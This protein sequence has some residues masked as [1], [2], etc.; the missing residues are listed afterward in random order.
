[1]TFTYRVLA[2]A[3][4]LACAT[5]VYAEAT[6]VDYVTYS[7]KD[8]VPP[9]KVTGD[10]LTYIAGVGN[11]LKQDATSFVARLNP[12][13]WMAVT[14]KGA[15][16]LLQIHDETN[17][18]NF[19]AQ[20]SSKGVVSV[21]K[22]VDWSGMNKAQDAEHAVHLAVGYLDRVRTDR[23]VFVTESASSTAEKPAATEKTA[24]AEKTVTAEKTATHASPSKTLEV[25]AEAKA[26]QP[27]G[28]ATWQKLVDGNLRFTSGKVTRPNQSMA[29][30][31][32]TAGGQKPFAVVVT[33]SDSRLPPELL[34]DQGLGDLFV[35]RT[36]GEVV[37]EVELGSIEYAIEHLGAQYIVVMGHKKCGAV[38]ATVKGG[39]LPPNIEA[40]AEQIRPAVEAARFFKGDLL[41]NSIRE[42][43]K[44]VL[45][46]IK[47]SEILS[48]AFKSGKLNFKAAYYDI[49]TGKVSAL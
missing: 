39:E 17:E 42:N 21:Q 23:P 15:G 44:V 28:D 20:V 13:H 12:E 19:R 25:T 5:L 43:A 31:A 14:R 30:V 22:G 9:V 36:A 40:I 49:E 38:D 6:F 46:K 18:F 11:L 29:R 3:L 34:F 2:A 27:V 41:D 1:M 33:C 47:G 7:P 35:V 8:Q 24:I 48:E 37:T 10:N 16:W 32:E 26:S 45:K 4:F